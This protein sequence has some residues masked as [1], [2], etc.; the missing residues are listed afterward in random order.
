[1]VSR[2]CATFII[3]SFQNVFIYIYSC[4]CLWWCVEARKEFDLV[5]SKASQLLWNSFWAVFC[6]PA[7]AR[8]THSSIS[9]I[10]F[11]RMSENEYIQVKESS[12]VGATSRRYA[13]CRQTIRR[14]WNRRPKEK[15]RNRKFSSHSICFAIFIDD[16]IRADSEFPK[17]KT[18]SSSKPFHVR[19]AEAEN[20]SK[21]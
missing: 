15:K 4:C 11:A 12:S 8:K 2:H 16:S 5:Q 9:P 3:W 19:F 20:R 21:H 7:G 6:D 18:I 14:E 10:S 1:M 17:A 13:S